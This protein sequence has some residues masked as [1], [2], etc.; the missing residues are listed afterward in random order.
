MDEILRKLEGLE[1]RI[2]L[3]EARLGLAAQARGTPSFGPAAPPPPPYAAG[4]AAPPP[5]PYAPAPAPARGWAFT[6][7]LHGKNVESYIGRWILGI[8]GAVAIVFGASFF[9]K[10]AFESNLIGEA[11]RVILGLAGGL[12]FIVLGEFLRP[13]LTKY[14]YILSGGGLALFYLSIYAAF[15]FYGLIGQSA[16]FGSMAAVTAFGVILA[17]WADGIELAGLAA[18]GGFLTP[19]LVSTGTSNDF[20]FFAYLTIINAG[21]LA[22]AFFKKW[23]PLTLLGFTAT[24]FN[25]VSWYAAYYDPE[26][27]FFTAYVLTV[28]YLIYAAA[29]VI[30]N[31]ATAKPATQAD[32]VILTVNAGWYFGWLFYLLQPK[33]EAALG[34]IA[35]GLAGLYILLAYLSAALRAEDKH[36]MLFLGGIAVVFLTIAVPLELDQNAITIAWAVEAAVLFALGAM[37][38]N[39]GMRYAAI[40][41]LAIAS[42]RLVALDSGDVDF[43]RFIPVF[44]K[45]FF[46]Y[47]A[48]IAA[49]AV[50]GALALKRPGAIAADEKI[51]PA[52][53]WSLVNVL[54]LAAVTLELFA[55]F[56]AKVFILERRKAQEINRQT[57]V[58]GGPTYAGAN[59][60][61]AMQQ[62]R[63]SQEYRSFMNQR[64]ASISVF[65]ALYAVL[66][67]TL[68]MLWRNALLRWSA[69]ILFGITIGKVFLFDLAALRTPYKIIS[70]TV[71]GAILL[72][73]SY[74]YFRYQKRLETSG[75]QP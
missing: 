46:T 30:A 5:P 58:S 31:I 4:P 59:R 68:G 72:A 25:F 35:A 53:L 71:L 38:G 9:L 56:D 10:Y 63:S 32:L 28:F 37:L 7:P 40:G 48:V 19:Y 54:V 27:L 36:L 44:N 6:T 69:L 24:V 66:L 34:F 61:Q 14:S 51:T 26:K 15:H 39:D 22:V 43:E 33:Y 21:I 50:M 20:A 29:G 16:A 13:R 52:F 55:F 2:A 12:F 11:G 62:V 23:H 70:F 8:T 45:R 47:V 42:I 60:Y 3:I 64:N 67:I 65:W 75:L 57:P 17:L 18:A 73:A 74:L 49:S 1:R 41:V